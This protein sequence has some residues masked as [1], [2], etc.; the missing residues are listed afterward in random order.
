VYKG[1]E[2][3]VHWIVDNKAWGT[4]TEDGST[5]W[6]PLMQMVAPANVDL[7]MLK[8]RGIEQSAPK[9]KL[10][11]VA[12]KVVQSAIRLA[13]IV[14]NKL[15]SAKRASRA[16]A[17]E[18]RRQSRLSRA[19]ASASEAGTGLSSRPLHMVS[20]LYQEDLPD[21]HHAKHQL[22]GRQHANTSSLNKGGFARANKRVAEKLAA[23]EKWAAQEEARRTASVRKKAAQKAEITA[24][25]TAR[26]SMS[27]R[28]I[29]A[30]ENAKWDQ[31]EAKLAKEEAR[32]EAMVRL[33]AEMATT[34]VS[35]CLS[36][37]KGHE[38]HVTACKFLPDSN[39]LVTGSQDYT[40]KVWDL[41]S[42]KCLHTLEGQYP[43]SW[44]VSFG[45]SVLLCSLRSHAREQCGFFLV[46]ASTGAHSPSPP[47]T[48]ADIHLCPSFRCHPCSTPRRPRQRDQLGGHVETERVL[49]IG[50]ARV[51][52][53]RQR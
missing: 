4:K 21:G 11:D 46:Q 23:E 33:K 29:E 6:I 37:L 41:S 39:R 31:E 40:A 26:A 42:G 28:E 44:G 15:I 9:V 8:Q 3:T 48:H 38:W 25:A 14:V 34:P 27:Q 49:G 30:E 7:E 12:D 51:H 2:V 52:S 20:E 50:A 10:V 24:T 19:R 22:H 36:T 32:K 5:N 1:D 16:S 17:H 45:T 43:L 13:A 18:V 53:H 35:K 47:T